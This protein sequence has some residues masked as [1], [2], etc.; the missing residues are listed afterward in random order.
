VAG[1]IAVLARMHRLAY[2]S[3]RRNVPALLTAEA[4][5]A[6]WVRLYMLRSN[7]ICIFVHHQMAAMASRQ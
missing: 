5:F 2:A 1:A 3:A 6:S 4:Y 7:P